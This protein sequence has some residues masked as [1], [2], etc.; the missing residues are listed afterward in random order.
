MDAL[1]VRLLYCVRWKNILDFLSFSSNNFTINFYLL[2]WYNW[3][4]YVPWM[5]LVLERRRLQFRGSSGQWR[6]VPTFFHAIAS[7]S[8]IQEVNTVDVLLLAKA[9]IFRRILQ[10]MLKSERQIEASLS[11]LKVV[12]HMDFSWGSLPL[13]SS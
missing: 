6:W 4:F 12:L 7:T 13:V 11:S 9:N 5:Q 3:W 10:C 8:K 2:C 1:Q